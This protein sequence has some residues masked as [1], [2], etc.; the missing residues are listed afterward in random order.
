MTRIAR[1]DRSARQ[2]L[3]WVAVSVAAAYYLGVQIGMALRFPP[4]TT[5]VLWPPNA[6]LT[7]ALLL[8]PVRYW[9]VCL[10]AAFPAHV[11]SQIG[12]GFPPALVVPL[13]VTN[14]S[15][16]LFAAS[17]V[18]LLNNAPERLDT[19]RRV[20]VFIAVA[21][22]GAPVM[23]SFADAAVVQLHRGEAYWAV[24][25]T[26][27]FA[28]VLTE[29]SVVPVVLAIGAQI[30]R[31]TQ[32]RPW[33]V[34]E[35]LALGLSLTFAARWV[36]D[37]GVVAMTL[38]GMPRAPFLFLLP[39]FF[40]AAVRFGV[41]GSSAALFLCALA[42]S[43]AAI[44]GNRPFEGLSPIDS[45]QALQ[46]Y[47]AVLGVPFLCVGGLL[48]ERRQAASALARRLRVEALLSAIGGAFMHARK[49]DLSSAFEESLRLTG[50][51]F[52]AC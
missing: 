44:G 1:I 2:P 5:S 45:L 47:L 14:C 17:G 7:A 24:W 31:R 11:F 20:V 46:I 38:P 34:V 36:L 50:T 18:R 13:F 48:E 3:A 41:G 26:R 40:W 43:Y 25:R 8:V 12:A 10:L 23:S 15:E 32:P 9:W 49:T 42:A 39:F 37:G 6:T 16:A 19:F 28:N 52:K 27:T 33:R 30:A 22:L 21:G 51:F 29:L 4:A 35:A